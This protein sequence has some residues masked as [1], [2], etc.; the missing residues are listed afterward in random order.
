[1]LEE[2]VLEELVLEELVLEE[3]V[4]EELVLEVPEVESS[5]PV[6]LFG[7]TPFELH[8]RP[9]PTIDG[10]RSRRKALRKER[11]ISSSKRLRG[12]C[13]RKSRKT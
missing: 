11:V 8:A 5:P 9:R 4:L 3:L 7:A 12:H 1:V 13:E 6:P 2:L 10:R